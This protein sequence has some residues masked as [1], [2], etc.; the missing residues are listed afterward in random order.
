MDERDV[1]AARSLADSADA[2][3]FLALKVGDAVL[4]IVNPETDMVESRNVDLGLRLGI[5][6]SHQVNFNCA[7]ETFPHREHVLI[8]IFGPG[9]ELKDFRQSQVV[10]PEVV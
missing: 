1:V 2:L 8:H 6:G 9:L 4:Q 5:E 10:G 7:E 3:Y